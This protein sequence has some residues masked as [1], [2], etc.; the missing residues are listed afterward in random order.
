MDKIEYW[1]KHVLAQRVSGVSQ[2][3]YCEDAGLSASSFGYWA[4]R[5]RGPK[6]V[7]GKFES[8]GAKAAIEVIIGAAVIRVLPGSDLSELRRIVEAL[9][10]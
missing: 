1:K 3:Q 9:R 6:S 7:P 5:L 10:C 2:T 8:I 4:T